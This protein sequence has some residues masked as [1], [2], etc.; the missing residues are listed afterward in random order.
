MAKPDRQKRTT[1]QPA[2]DSGVGMTIEEWV[3]YRMSLLVWLTN[4][5]VGHMP[6]HPVAYARHWEME[7]PGKP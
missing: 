3:V 7:G 5:R 6:I 4:G 1:G 2:K